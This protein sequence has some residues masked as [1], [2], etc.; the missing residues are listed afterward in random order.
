MSGQGHIHFLWTQEVFDEARKSLTSRFPEDSVKLKLMFD[1]ITT[2]FYDN[3]VRGY[4][5]LI[6]TLGCKDKDDEHVLAGAIHGKANVLLTYNTRDFPQKL[7]HNLAVMHPDSF[8]GSW[9]GA[10][11]EL[12]VLIVSQ[13]LEK[14]ENPPIGARA[15][16][17][18]VNKIDC[19]M[20]ASFIRRKAKSIDARIHVIRGT[21]SR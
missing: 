17:E 4:D 8:L 6:G 20:L 11:P 21:G 2:H 13:W 1:R 10:H 3:E 14:F 15:A 5:K 19:S 12:G 18:L 16:A 7:T 9:L